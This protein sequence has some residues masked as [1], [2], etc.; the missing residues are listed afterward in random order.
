MARKRSRRHR[1]DPA[2]F[3]DLGPSRHV[4]GKTRR[5]RYLLV[6]V[7][8]TGGLA[9]AAP[10]VISTTPLR[11]HVLAWA[12]PEGAG[13]IT[14]ETASFSWWGGQSLTGL[15][16]LDPAGNP[17][18]AA[19]EASLARSL[20]GLIVSRT[21][22]TRI[23]LVRPTV[24]LET[25]PDGSN[26][27]DVF[28]AMDGAPESDGPD[29]DGTETPTRSL[30]IEVVEGALVGRDEAAGLA[31]RLEQVDLDAELQPGG[32]WT[33]AGVAQA[34]T[35]GGSPGMLRFRLS[36]TGGGAQRL[37]LFG[38]RL[39]LAPLE[40]WIARSL[41]GCRL[42]GAASA[43]LQVSWNAPE[44][45]APRVHAEGKL[46]LADLQLTAN[47]L[48]GDVLELASANLSTQLVWQGEALTLDRF[49]AEGDWFKT[50]AHGVFRLAEIVEASWD[51]LPASDANLTAQFD[52]APL[53][54]QLPQTLRL[55]DGVRVDAGRVQLTAAS[56]GDGAGRRWDVTAGIEDLHG[57][58]GRREIKWSQPVFARFA[59]THSPSGPRFDH[60]EFESPFATA[61]VNSV[62]SGIDGQFQ[63]DLAQLSQE[64]S[65]FVDLADWRMR[66]AGAGRF[67][68]RET[69]GAGVLI[70]TQADF[71]E[72]DLR[73]QQRP[74]WRDRQLSIDLQASAQRSGW[75][76]TEIESG[77]LTLRGVDDN[78]AIELLAPVAWSER[79]T[80]CSLR[81]RGNGPL[82][83]WAGR[84]R[85][86]V[87]GIPDEMGGAATVDA[88]IGVGDGL[89]EMNEAVVDVADFRLRTTKTIVAEPRVQLKGDYRWQRDA[90][91]VASRQL[92]LTTST[93]AIR[94]RDVSLEFPAVGPPTAHGEVAFRANLERL[95]AWLGWM[96]EGEA[97]WP[98]GQAVGSIKL[99]SDAQQ[100]HADVSLAGDQ[101]QW[102]QRDASQSDRAVVLWNEPHAEAGGK[103]TYSHQ[104][105]RLQ[106]SE[107][108]LRGKTIE[109]VGAAAVENVRTIAAVQGDLQITY[110]AQEVARL[111]AEMLG[112]GVKLEGANQ[113]RVSFAGQLREKPRRG[114]ALTS[115]APLAPVHWSHRWQAA[116]EAGWSRGD[117]YGLPVGDARL[118]ARLQNGK[119][120]FAP[121]DIQVG[122]GRLT[123]QPVALL[124]PPPSMLE[125][126]PGPLVTNVAVSPQVSESV[127]KYAAPILVGATRVQGAFS[128][129]LDGARIPL[130]S[131]ERADVAGRLTVHQLQILP[132]PTT[133]PLVNTVRQ[134]AALARGQDLL[135]GAPVRQGTG[136][137]IDGKAIDVR[138]VD[139]RVYHRNLEFLI[140]G[141][142]VRSTGWVGFDES[143]QLAIEVPVQEKWVRGSSTFRPLAGQIIRIPVE[144]SL[145]RWRV[146]DRVIGQLIQQ[147]AQQ[148]IGNEINRA[149]D[150]LLKPR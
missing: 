86:W 83:S 146:D 6:L 128:V 89:L 96:A 40:P 85:P 33:A 7:I 53:A 133:A 3:E 79:T 130:E 102:L 103:L 104:D 48:S 46:A 67:N 123:A 72:I 70:A 114:P 50:T 69:S 1:S 12:L 65:Q 5:R 137:T 105:D 45:G 107:L 36:P 98:R 116:S 14:C 22:L 100:A 42:I 90:S 63:F 68:L 71:Q 88:K 124:D 132:G 149:L 52:L 60:A 142:P 139:G 136:V 106:C 91:S 24:F 28:G 77:A 20:A 74:V 35:V 26:W 127:L 131:P 55:R 27:E 30:E 64:L 21:S 19:E 82:E 110:A 126:S 99:S 108:Q 4:R 143:M 109:L 75:R 145:S 58:D 44:E 97:A 34:L 62:D 121:I 125:L 111:L 18:A 119:I 147:G 94:G 59:A 15:N 11:N 2:T 13:T 135:S 25:L 73:H 150:R 9:A 144:G 92:E 148:V 81:L 66:G 57:S 112:P 16:W 32:G 141:V 49:T 84:L 76:L 78:L 118:S 38:E 87:E 39:P 120:Q 47:V 93:V 134:L 80:N 31:W 122:E 51:A 56:V 23:K 117:L 95:A 17:L 10:T 101:L 138:I 37:E 29:S 8:I 54:R 140:D 113:A 129:E 61:K 41:P 115:T 43:D